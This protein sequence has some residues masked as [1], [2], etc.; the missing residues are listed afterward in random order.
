MIIIA[1]FGFYRNS[2]DFNYGFDIKSDQ[3][4]QIEYLNRRIIYETEE[5]YDPRKDEYNYESDDSERY[6]NHYFG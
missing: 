4:V 1:L 2:D 3:Q 5:Q 6:S